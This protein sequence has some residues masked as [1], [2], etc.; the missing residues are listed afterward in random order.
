[1]TS[2]TTARWQAGTPAS[3]GG[4]F[5]AQFRTADEVDLRPGADEAAASNPATP[6]KTLTRLSFSKDELVRL[7]VAGNPN[8]PVGDL[9]RMLNRGRDVRAVVLANPA[10]PEKDLIG[11]ARRPRDGDLRALAGNPSL[12][13]N[14][15][16]A[17]META[18]SGV[19]S[20]LMSHSAAPADLAVMRAPEQT[21]PEPVSFARHASD[22]VTDP[23]A[24]PEELRNLAYTRDAALRERVAVHPNTPPRILEGYLRLDHQTLLQ[25]LRNPSLS[26]DAIISRFSRPIIDTRTALGVA[27][28]RTQMSERFAR[29]VL[30]SWTDQGG[31]NM[32]QRVPALLAGN[33]ATPPAVLREL[34]GWRE[35]E[36]RRALAG[37]PAVT[38]A[39]A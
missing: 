14:V 20:I 16:R 29:F 11:V 8:T 39:A 26:E 37:N 25:V 23:D 38:P 28:S 17:A 30:D 2:T 13:G 9:Q 1:M 21:R 7:A 19:R 31:F 18:D 3:Q 27:A 32:V 12:T 22:V 36:V 15:I 5:R 4:R 24:A 35:P 10:M 33:P 34:A 6:A